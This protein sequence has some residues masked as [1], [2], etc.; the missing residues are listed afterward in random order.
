MIALRITTE[1]VQDGAFVLVIV[2]TLIA[3]V[4][5]ALIYGGN[6]YDDDRDDASVQDK[7]DG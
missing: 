5:L 4:A 3:F 7:K 6:R 1:Q 2:C